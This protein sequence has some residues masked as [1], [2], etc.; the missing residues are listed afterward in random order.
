MFTALSS[1][2]SQVNLSLMISNIKLTFIQRR[3]PSIAVQSQAFWRADH[4]Q[5]HAVARLPRKSEVSRN[6]GLRPLC[7]GSRRLTNIY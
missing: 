4:T 6:I 3:R 1:L 5:L 2:P 7:L